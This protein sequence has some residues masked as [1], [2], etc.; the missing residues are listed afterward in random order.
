MISIGGENLPKAI[1]TKS[2]EKLGK[3]YKDRG[4]VKDLE[5][6]LKQIKV[7]LGGK[8]TIKKIAENIYDIHIKH[9]NKFCPIGG[10]FKPSIASLFQNHVCKPCISGFLNAIYSQFKF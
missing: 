7:V 8:P 10:T 5:S 2:G 4:M 9:H 3:L 6:M 1:P